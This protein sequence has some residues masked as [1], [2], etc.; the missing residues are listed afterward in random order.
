MRNPSPVFP[1][2]FVGDYVKAFVGMHFVGVDDLCRKNGRDVDGE[3]GISG[4][5]G[6]RHDHHHRVLFNF[7]RE[8]LLIDQ[9]LSHGSA[10]YHGDACS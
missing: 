9:G 1:G 10:H 6:S 2:D 3:P 4:P 8:G 5:G 7:F